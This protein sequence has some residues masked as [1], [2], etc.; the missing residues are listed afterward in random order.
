MVAAKAGTYTPV[1]D[2]I[3]WWDARI[4]CLCW[5]YLQYNHLML[6]YHLVGVVVS[7]ISHCLES[8]LT[9]SVEIRLSTPYVNK[10][11]TVFTLSIQLVIPN[12]EEYS[13]GC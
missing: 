12:A 10:K 2:G 1:E 7:Q 5:V 13:G 8:Y 3:D 6:P 9:A 11:M 4:E